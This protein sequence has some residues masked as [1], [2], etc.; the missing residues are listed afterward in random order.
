MN[1]LRLADNLFLPVDMVTDTVGILAIKGSGKT[2]TFLVLVEEMVKNALPIIILDTM[3]VCWGIRSS[4]DG[5][6]PGFPIVILGGGHGDVPLESTAGKVIA[7]W[8]VSERQP[9]VLDI[10]E[11]SKAEASRFV[12]D[13]VSRL[14]QVNHEPVHIVVDEADEWIPQRPFRE[15]ARTLRAFEVLVR[16]GRAR[17]VGITLV[18]QRPAT[19]N[20][21]VL[22]QVST[23]IVGRMIAPQDRKAVQ[24]WIEAHGTEHQKEEFWNS[25]ASLSTKEKWVWSP[26]RDIFKKVLIR[27]RE[28][29]DSSATPKVGERSTGPRSL[30]GVDLEVLR[31]RIASTIEKAKQDDPRELRRQIAELKRQVEKP[32]TVEVEKPVEIPVLR[33]EQ[34]KSLKESIKQVEAINEKLDKIGQ[35]IVTS[36]RAF[37]AALQ[38]CLEKSPL[39]RFS[40]PQEKVGYSRKSKIVIDSN[41]EDVKLRFG[42]RRMLEVLVRRYPAKLTKSQLA[43]LSGLTASGGTFTNYYGT[44]KRA[45][46]I[47]EIIDGSGTVIYASRLGLDYCGEIPRTPQTTEEVVDMWR[48]ALRAGERRL[49]DVLIDIYPKSISRSELAERTDLTASAGTFSN[50]LGTLRRN[51]LAE[52]NADQVKA[53]QALFLER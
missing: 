47:E 44:L 29:F 35:E 39:S 45:G 12:L 22:T 25:L 26:A 6:S 7:D 43:T 19:L 36:V 42:E 5:K 11:F 48:S 3:G 33:D 28:T 16:R 32:K 4:A 13:F 31:K 20:K 46:L 24:A 53:G 40:V 41:L 1:K 34:I 27:K 8:V 9:A 14:F 23:L 2:Y 15:E 10:S 50:Y 21:N 49:L 52:I 51:G 30:A 38:K 18:T 37:G 17:G